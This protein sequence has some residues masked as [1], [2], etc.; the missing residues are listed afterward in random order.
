MR[1]KLLSRKI[2]IQN[3]KHGFTKL[4]LYTIRTRQIFLAETYFGEGVEWKNAATKKHFAN[5]CQSH[6][7]I[8]L[9]GK[10]KHTPHPNQFQNNLIILFWKCGNKTFWFFWWVLGD[11]FFKMSNDVKLAQI[12][13][14]F[15]YHQICIFCRKKSGW[16]IWPGWM[17]HT[18]S[19]PRSQEKWVLWLRLHV[20]KVNLHQERKQ[21]RLTHQHNRKKSPCSP[22]YEP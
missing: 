5:S 12:R 18:S 4:A 9:V 17:S 13:R 11:V 20:G 10:R 7:I 8:H 22:S 14:T 16:K 19:G 15:W 6:Q 3:G 1:C 21:R 2:A